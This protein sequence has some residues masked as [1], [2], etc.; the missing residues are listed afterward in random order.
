MISQRRLS[1]G[2]E[3]PVD[4]EAVKAA[5]VIGKS[6]THNG[7][8]LDQNNPPR[9][10]VSRS[11]SL[12]RN[13]LNSNNNHVRK[14]FSMTGTRQTSL[15]SPSMN[16][17]SGTVRTSSMMRSDPRQ[18]NTG[19][20]RSYSLTVPRRTVS[21]Q[22]AQN[23]FDEF[24]GPQHQ[25]VIHRSPSMSAMPKAT[26]TV[27]KYVPSSKGLIVMEVPVEE[28]QQQQQ[29]AQQQIQR[30]RSLTRS[31]SRNFSLPRSNSRTNS[32]T[33]SRT[34]SLTGPRSV[35]LNNARTN[36]IV[37]SS[38][39]TSSLTGSKP[40]LQPPKRYS[41]LNSASL[42]NGARRDQ[43]MSTPLE[44]EEEDVKPPAV[45]KQTNPGR[46]VSG[47]SA[48]ST[49]SRKS[50]GT[51][52]PSGRAKTVK[53][54][55]KKMPATATAVP[56]S[57]EK[58]PLRESTSSSSQASSS[59]SL[60]S[61]PAAGTSDLLKNQEQPRED[62]D[63]IL[64]DER[65]DQYDDSGNKVWESKL[66][67]V[68]KQDLDEGSQQASSN[69]DSISPPLP[70][71][72][73]VPS[74]SPN[75]PT[76]Q[77]AKPSLTGESQ[78]LEE[79][80]VPV[81][82][83]K[84]TE[85]AQ[86]HAS[87]E[88]KNVSEP[89]P[90]EDHEEHSPDRME[91]SAEPE[92]RSTLAAAQVNDKMTSIAEPP[93]NEPSQNRLRDYLEGADEQLENS[94]IE[95]VTSQNPN[96]SLVK[97]LRIPS[98][99]SLQA[100]T[101]N[102]AQEEELAKE[103][104][105]ELDIM[106]HN[107]NNN[108][109]DENSD[110]LFV[111]SRED[112]LDDFNANGDQVGRKAPSLPERNPKRGNANKTLADGGPTKP[113]SPMKSALKKTNPENSN[114]SMYAESSP[115]NQAYLSLTTAE[116]TR[117]NAQLTGSDT[118]QRKNTLRSVNR[119]RTMQNNRATHS[120]SPPPREAL[121][122]K[123]HSHH[124]GIK[125]PAERKAAGMPQTPRTRNSM[126]NTPSR[127]Q[128]PPKGESV[129]STAKSKLNNPILYPREPPQ[130]RSSFEKT[131]N[132]DNNVGMS[133]LSLR[134]AALLENNYQQSSL[135]NHFRGTSA[136]PPSA[137]SSSTESGASSALFSSAGFKSRFQDSDS[138]DEGAQLNGANGAGGKPDQ[139]HNPAGSSGN[140]FSFFKHKDNGESG[141][142]LGKLSLKTSNGSDQGAD[143]ARRFG[144]GGFD[145]KVRTLRD[146]IPADDELP[147][148]GKKNVFGKKLKK[149]F[150]R[151][152]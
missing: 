151:N 50:L 44:E 101:S 56:P 60:S 71:Q 124:V 110:E 36:S 62:Q 99:E 83:E 8:N 103:V 108:N 29:L 148:G 86:D 24:G 106:G 30:N 54:V 31:S 5:S 118:I 58:A 135:D 91:H 133:K 6:M 139:H 4:G 122:P 102:S 149:L 88:Q 19:I 82:K 12:M 65:E 43:F 78:K 70:N 59:Q 79:E 76:E 105:H 53:T 22:D 98:R 3:K 84:E 111:D 7:K 90:Q 64:E 13:S 142:K 96:D 128:Q 130:K 95:S 89:K 45:K 68:I 48:V 33:G 1:R 120:L 109:S 10:P 46:T 47:N 20:S 32:L 145:N 23:A 39:R 127:G 75:V 80:I 116:N 152:R 131:R 97:P 35:S 137:P 61:P 114:P 81:T 100:D 132:K 94:G 138:E 134:D 26:K 141:K 49:A 74:S 104:R 77:I 87:Q 37:R 67:N 69:S 93:V 136:V 55:K 117:L 16:G 147:D 57:N 140:G 51:S 66:E 2:L 123:R 42:V 25:G 146:E 115:A 11:G 72:S 9:A 107:D 85:E 143:S 113:P 126:I 119:P 21:Q 40:N 28:L 17:G 52:L 125:T 27:K 73:S 121:V 34:N 18:K 15:R 129:N 92:E 38:S 150:G 112:V 41:S 14:T 144:G 63:V